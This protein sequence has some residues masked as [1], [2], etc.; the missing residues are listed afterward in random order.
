MID[1]VTAGR[2]IVKYVI[3]GAGK[4]AQ[5]YIERNGIEHIEAIV[6]GDVRRTG[7][8]FHGIEI[9]G[10]MYL[11]QVTF[12]DEMRLLV[13]VHD[14]YPVCMVLA[15]IVNFTYISYM[16]HQCEICDVENT[17][18]GYA[19]SK[20]EAN[21]KLDIFN[22]NI[23]VKAPNY[24]I[25]FF[26]M[27]IVNAYS[28]IK[29]LVEEYLIDNTCDVCIIF[30][31]GVD[32][33][34]YCDDFKKLKEQFQKEKIKYIDYTEYSVQDDHPDICF[35]YLEESL[36]TVSEFKQYCNMTV[37][38][39]HRP[40]LIHSTRHERIESI[41]GDDGSKGVTYFICNNFM[42]EWL[43]SRFNYSQKILNIG[44][45]KLDLLYNEIQYKTNIPIEWRRKI[46]NKK[47]FLYNW[48][49]ILGKRLEEELSF[50]TYEK[51]LNYLIN[52]FKENSGIC[53][54]IR[55]RETIEKQVPDYIWDSDKRAQFKAVCNTCDNIILDESET[56]YAAF[57]CADG[58]FSSF[59]SIITYFLCIGKPVCF[60]HGK[61]EYSNECNEWMH[62]CSEAKNEEDINDFI[63]KVIDSSVQNSIFT[64]QYNGN[65]CKRIKKRLDHDM[66]I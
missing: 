45:P 5:R 33:S 54:I 17:K 19:Y 20:L 58:L 7:E 46:R 41:F 61:G 28:A 12:N 50:N 63:K 40:V 60:L 52:Y 43:S 62:I 39:Q 64:K 36:E 4:I 57:A 9:F 35:F 21:L 44:F 18:I 55:T 29:P 42:T 10:K 56:Y 16:N 31:K 38:V 32:T 22:A 14:W 65:V 48:M 25:R 51:Y 8:Y 2:M 1:S 15:E 30:P 66:K 11:K 49:T 13:T 3:Y 47:V 26:M 53:L 24:K 6:D 34:I 27:S 23:M 37:M 59:S